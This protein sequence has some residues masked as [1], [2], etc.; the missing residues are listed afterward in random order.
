MIKDSMAK[1]M[2][3][4]AFKGAFRGTFLMVFAVFGLGLGADAHAGNWDYTKADNASPHP[5][6]PV[7][8]GALEAGAENSA[9]GISGDDRAAIIA[10]IGSDYRKKCASAADRKKNKCA[11]P[12]A[13]KTYSLG[14][15]LPDNAGAA[16]IPDKLRA[17]LKPGAGHQYIQA[18][19]DV[20]LV[21]SSSRIV[22]DAVTLS[23]AIAE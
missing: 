5:R 9:A 18:N 12:D 23:S 1:H 11:S 14:A 7:G 19:G 2:L 13:A 3:N 22:V 4:G 8:R 6:G 17:Q 15:A 10:F 20:L 16:N 21:N